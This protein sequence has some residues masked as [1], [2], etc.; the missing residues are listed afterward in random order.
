MLSRSM[1]S[2]SSPW[3]TTVGSGGLT[4]VGRTMAG[5]RE[6]S[7]PSPTNPSMNRGPRRLLFVCDRIGNVLTGGAVA[8]GG[9]KAGFATTLTVTGLNQSPGDV[10]EGPVNVTLGAV[11]PLPTA[12]RESVL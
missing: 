10:P 8:G 6:R 1:F 12:K 5:L 7:T 9:T 4:S 2:L 3:T 11:A